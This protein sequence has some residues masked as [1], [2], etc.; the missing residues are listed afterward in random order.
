MSKTYSM[1]G[2][3]IG[4]AA[5]NKTLIQALTRIK[6]YL[7]YGAFTPIQVAATAALNG[8]QECIAEARDTYRERRDILIDGLRAAGWDIPAP[9]ASMFAW[10]PLPKDFAELGSLAF[11]KLLL[12]RPISRCRRGSASGNTAMRMSASRW[13]RTSTASARPSATSRTVL[14]DPSRSIDLYLR[15]VGD[16]ITPL[17]ARA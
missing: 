8:P 3:R 1:A 4:F 15:G 10:A 17:K 14:A 9:A 11:S 5:G 2:W 7:D 16:N 6:S 13:S 12:T